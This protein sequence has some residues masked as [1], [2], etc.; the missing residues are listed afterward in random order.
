[1]RKPDLFRMDG[2]DDCI[3]GIVAGPNCPDAVCYDIDLVLQ[4]LQDD[5]DMTRD[6]AIEF[7]E[8]NMRDASVGKGTPVFMRWANIKTIDAL[9]NREDPSNN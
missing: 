9:L 1:M 8:F 4:K 2:F 3:V 5:M 7:F 6:E